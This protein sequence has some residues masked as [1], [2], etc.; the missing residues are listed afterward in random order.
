M[1]TIRETFHKLIRYKFKNDFG[2]VRIS[3][4][5]TYFLKYKT[6]STSE[7]SLHQSALEHFMQQYVTHPP[8]FKLAHIVELF[9]STHVDL[10]RKILTQ[11]R[12]DVLQIIYE[13]V[14]N[15]SYVHIFLNQILQKYNSTIL[16]LEA[17]QASLN[18]VKPFLLPTIRY[19][20]PSPIHPYQSREKVLTHKKGHRGF[21]SEYEYKTYW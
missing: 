9:T 4:L 21:V 16:S 1:K 19:H 8:K 7:Y 14:P 10:V 12:L 13:Y 2:H 6:Q 17:L 5:D 11:Y 3:Y 18:K 15:S 20:Y